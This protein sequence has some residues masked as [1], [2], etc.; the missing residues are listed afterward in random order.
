MTMEKIHNDYEEY[1]VWYNFEQI[2]RYETYLNM[3]SNLCGF[4]FLECM[5]KCELCRNRF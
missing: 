3:V 5:I 2:P 1:L 4:F